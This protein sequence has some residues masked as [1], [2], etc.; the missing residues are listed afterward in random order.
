MPS[1]GS[2]PTERH[3]I[4]HSLIRFDKRGTGLSEQLLKHVAS[5]EERIDD[6][7]AVMDAVGSDSAVIFGGSEGGSMACLFAAT[8][9]VRTRSLIVWGG[10]ATW[11]KG[12]DAPWGIPRET[13]EA[14][15]EDLAIHGV[16]EE[17][18]R[19]WGAGMGEA[20][21]QEEVDRRSARSRQEPARCRCRSG[22]DEHA[23]RHPFG[24]S[25]HPRP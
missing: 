14:V 18:V 2:S 24:P 5:L 22:A 4:V 19:G 11:V 17:Y 15:I 9:P 12:P 8:Y 13:Y 16:T 23:D 6:I 10:Q 25:E 21:P 1:P 20:A 7:R 3:A